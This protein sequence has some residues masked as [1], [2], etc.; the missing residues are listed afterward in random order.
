MGGAAGIAGRL[1][2]L[3]SRT[4]AAEQARSHPLTRDP[5]R[6]PWSSSGCRRRPS[7]SRR[8]GSAITSMPRS[9]AAR[10]SAGSPRTSPSGPGR[11]QSELIAHSSPGGQISCS[12]PSSVR[13]SRNHHG[14]PSGSTSALSGAT[15]PK[16]PSRWIDQP[17]IGTTISSMPSH[18]SVSS[19][20]ARAGLVAA[21]RGGVGGDVGVIFANEPPSSMPVPWMVRRI[22]MPSAPSAWW[23]CSSSPLRIVGASRPR[24]APPGT[25][26]SGSRV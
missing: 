7:G 26:T 12:M 21:D 2:S 25:V 3:H 11:M 15:M 4:L 9:R 19:Q 23:M 13:R 1:E 10:A 14:R 17:P 22:G 8:T 5:A 16:W 18:A 20:L 6:A 24:I